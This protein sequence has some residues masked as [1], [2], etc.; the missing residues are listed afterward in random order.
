[1]KKIINFMIILL[2]IS[3]LYSCVAPSLELKNYV[4]KEK[5]IV[6]NKSIN[7][8][9]WQGKNKVNVI[10]VKRGAETINRLTGNFKFAVND[11]V[12]IL[13]ESKSAQFITRYFD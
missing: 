3:F 6:N 10:K 2:T 1:M 12:Y 4:V 11:T 7:S 8:L 9:D 13:V 5:S